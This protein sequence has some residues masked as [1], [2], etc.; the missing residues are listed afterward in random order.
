[1]SDVP[2][3][4]SIPV[5]EFPNNEKERAPRWDISQERSFVENLLGSRLNFLLVFFSIFVGGAVNAKDN[6]FLQAI[7]VSVAAI[8]VLHLA[9]AIFRTHRKLEFLLGLVFR[10]RTHPARLTEDFPTGRHIVG[11]RVPV[12][13]CVVLVGWAA[14]DWIL[15]AVHWI[16]ELIHC[17]PQPN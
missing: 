17:L 15:L 11:R 3:I 12:L 5:E 8:I 9:T 6:L 16:P 10:Q 7:V 2:T 13:C 1:M 14:V 4:E